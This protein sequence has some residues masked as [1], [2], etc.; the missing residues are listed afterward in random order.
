M[1][2]ETTWFTQSC[3]TYN[4][5]RKSQENLV[6]KREVKVEKPHAIILRRCF[7]LMTYFCIEIYI[8]CFCTE[9]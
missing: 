6:M 2:Y 1:E 9:S 4:T 3:C 5:P 8:F 7:K